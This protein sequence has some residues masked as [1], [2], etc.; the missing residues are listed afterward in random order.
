MGESGLT[1]AQPIKEGFNVVTS[2]FEGMDRHPGKLPNM[3]KQIVKL[4]VSRE[5]GVIIGG[6]AI[7]GSSIAELVNLKQN[8]HLHPSNNSNWNTSAINCITRSISVE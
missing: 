2:S 1:E 7:G 6:E 4:I 3:H 5:S 8:K